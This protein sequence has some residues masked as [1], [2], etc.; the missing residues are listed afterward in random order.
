MK[1]NLLTLLSLI[2]F[3]FTQA[4]NVPNGGFE[5]WTSGNPDNWS[6]NNVPSVYTTVTQVTSAHGG[7]SAAKGTTT[8]T[9]FGNVQPSLMSSISGIGF[10]VTQAYS[11]LNFYYQTSLNAPCALGILITMQDAGG[12]VVG[13]GGGFVGNASSYTLASTPINYTGF[14]PV[15]C[16]I[17]FSIVDTTG[18]GISSTGNYFIVDDVG[19]S[20]LASVNEN[21]SAISISN[22]YPNPANHSASV[23]YYLASKSAVQ[24]QILNTQGKTIR[25]MTVSEQA[26]GKH[27]TDFDISAFSA[28][29]YFV[30]VKTDKGISAGKFIKE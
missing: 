6:T 11:T 18:N 28:G 17:Q 15:E 25:E 2:A 14:N 23:Q 1:K 5:N 22:V 4:Q 7:A 9:G 21:T 8:L 20:G 19:L 13:I 3:S 12:N 27:E 30:K 29:F 26:A 24:I 16:T 10:A